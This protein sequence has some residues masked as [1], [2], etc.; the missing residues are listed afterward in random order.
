MQVSIAIAAALPV[1]AGLWDITHGLSGSVGWADNHH[2]YLSGLLLAIGLGFWSAI[3]R[4]EART[5]RIRLLTTLVVI[6]GL[7]RLLGLAMGDAV[8]PMVV[9]A[10]GMELIVTPL[11]CLWQSCV[12]VRPRQVSRRFPQGFLDCRHICATS[13]RDSVR[14]SYAQRGVPHHGQDLRSH[15][16]PA[17]PHR[18]W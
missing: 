4:I 3:P 6:G 7:A 9:A 8:T 1:S 13:R 15:C 17:R 14:S 11:L 18:L 12:I 10:L 16:R 2:R 5:A